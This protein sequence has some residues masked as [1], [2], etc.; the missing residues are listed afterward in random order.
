MLNIKSVIMLISVLHL[1]YSS[2]FSVTCVVVVIRNVHLDFNFLH[3]ASQGTVHLFES[4]VN[5]LSL[6]SLSG[7]LSVT[8][9]DFIQEIS[10]LSLCLVFCLRRRDFCSLFTHSSVYVELYLS[11]RHRY[12]SHSFECSSFVNDITKKAIGFHEQVEL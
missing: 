3:K 4:P 9:C 2:L 6:L 10:C 8:L 1:V 5:V 11:Q 12:V 7:I